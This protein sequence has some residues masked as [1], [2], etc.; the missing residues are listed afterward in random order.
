MGGA[1]FMNYQ[2]AYKEVRGG[3]GGIIPGSGLKDADDPGIRKAFDGNDLTD[4]KSVKRNTGDLMMAVNDYTFI[5]CACGLG[6][7]VPPD[8]NRDTVACTKCGTIHSIEKKA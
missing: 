8:Y 2:Q 5:N 7:K 3:K 1:G 6:I 4:K